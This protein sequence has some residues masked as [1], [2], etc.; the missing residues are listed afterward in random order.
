[1]QSCSAKSEGGAPYFNGLHLCL[2]DDAVD[3]CRLELQRIE[4]ILMYPLN[5]PKLIC[6]HGFAITNGVHIIGS[7]ITVA[8]GTTDGWASMPK[9]VWLARPFNRH[10]GLQRSFDNWKR[11]H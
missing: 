7:S 5:L 1:M 10:C 4:R 11:L 8:R 9:S 3:S 6:R 2:E